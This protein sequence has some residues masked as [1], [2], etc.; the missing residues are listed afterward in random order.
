M[1]QI[2]NDQTKIEKFT[3]WEFERITQEVVDEL[4]DDAAKKKRET[5]E[6]L[7]RIQERIEIEKQENKFF[8]ILERKSQKKL[9]KW[10]EDNDEENNTE[11]N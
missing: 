4:D 9:F 3:E 10:G 7:K 2:P 6:D 11:K 5:L 1:K 8:Q